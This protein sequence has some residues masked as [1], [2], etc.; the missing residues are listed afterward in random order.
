MSASLAAL[1]Q[2][3]SDAELARLVPDSVFQRGVRLGADGAVSAFEHAQDGA[4]SAAQ[5]RVRGSDFT[6]YTVHLTHAA[7]S[8][9]RGGCDCAYADDGS[10]CK[11]QIALALVWRASVA[12]DTLAGP[13]S[14]P[15]APPAEPDWARFVCEQS[16]PALAAK[17][18]DWAARVPELRR[19]LQA[20]QR[21]A[22]PVGDAAAA[23]KVV[24][25]LLAAPPDLVEWRKVSAYVRKSQAV[26]GVLQGWTASDPAIALV[27]ADWA[28]TKLRRVWETADD[29]NGEIGGLMGELA[30]QWLA[31]LQAAGAQPA[32]FG[33]KVE[34]LWGVD[35][36]HLF[37][38]APALAAMGPA[39]AARY[40]ERVQAAWAHAQHSADQF[41]PRWQAK[42][43][44][45]DFHR[46][47]GDPGAEIDLLRGSLRDEAD[48]IDLIEALQH[49]ARAREALQAAEAAHRKYPVQR[50]IEELLLKAY[51]D[52]GWDAEALALQ[53]T[54]FDRQPSAAGYQAVLRAA[55]AAGH[56][57]AAERERLW[58]VLD[59]KDGQTG[60]YLASW[61]G[62]VRLDIWAKEGRFDDALAW[63]QT[64]RNLSP[65]TLRSFGLA[66]PPTHDAAAAELF[67]RALALRMG[68]A[69][70]PYAEE[71][72]LVRLCVARLSA[73]AAALWLAWLKVEYRPK[74]RFIE[75]LVAL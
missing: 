38:Q 34:R 48:H 45:Q 69:S 6:P 1:L 17:L 55:Q 31:A 30:V 46:A 41:G 14:E 4:L 11:H 5:G 68:Q 67:R 9:L 49:H 29:S 64:P 54:A 61:L 36:H 25:A 74:K 58:A 7:G 59:A 2:A 73:E 72:R 27:A 21:A 3:L 12:G 44:L 51:T 40:G 71:L 33:D 65:E 19:D 22:T 16:A 32:A 37:D 70:S 62:G 28:L 43:R 60:G 8:R 75:G 57:A 39:A 35:D 23:K 66:L 63:L 26:L 47:S 20:W 42:R 53:R 10:V 15:K 18:L 52:D 13:P 56:D 50:R 24:T